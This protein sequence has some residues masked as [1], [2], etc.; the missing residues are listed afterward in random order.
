M[1]K[2]ELRLTLQ[3][4]LRELEERNAALLV[5]LKLFGSHD[6]SENA[7][8]Q[9][10]KEKIESC[11]WETTNLKKRIKELDTTNNAN[12][13]VVY[14]VVVTNEEKTV[15]LTNEWETDPS[16]NKI[17]GNCPLGKVLLNKKAGEMGEV[18]TENGKYQIQIISI[19]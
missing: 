1:E 11:Q 19:Q 4:E 18:S 5:K 7:D 9:L 3:K 15:E 13:L 10:I 6:L 17:S 14:R 12:K 2:K 16:L 8:W